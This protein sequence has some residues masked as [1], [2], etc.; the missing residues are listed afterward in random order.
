[1]ISKYYKALSKENYLIGIPSRGREFMIEKGTGIWK[2]F[3]NSNPY[4]LSL[5]VRE[6]ESKRY[7]D[8]IEDIYE[9]TNGNFM[10]SITS[11]PDKYN[12][13]QKRQSFLE[14]AKANKI[15]Y[16]FIIDDDVDFY[17]R[18]ESLSS[19]YTNRYKDLMEK[20]TVN[21]ILWESI[22]LCNKK[23]PIVGLPLKQGSQGRKYAFEKNVPIIRFVCYHVPTLIKEEIKITGL[24][25]DFMS[26]RYVQLKVLNQGYRSLT[27]C[28]YAVGDMG[29]GYKGGCS[30]TRTV[31]LQKEAA[32]KLCKTFPKY[33]KLKIKENGLWNEKR[34][35]CKIDWK[36]FLDKEELKYLP[37]KEVMKEWS[38]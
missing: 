20:D 37:A 35:D 16:L 21:K 22:Q 7:Y 4:S 24:E 10:C 3:K 26:D 2:Y 28:R 8:K 17:Y 38:L 36:G 34:L 33:V 6:D 9:F 18:D 11:V 19:K 12:I 23:Y 30:T 13:A 14:I 1:M 5:I 15:D 31:E 25:T 29:T 32:K 27:N